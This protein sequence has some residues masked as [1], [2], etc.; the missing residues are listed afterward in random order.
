MSISVGK[1]IRLLGKNG[2]EEIIEYDLTENEKNDLIES[3][4]AVK[5]T[6]DAMENLS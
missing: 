5:E 6:V 3:A 4:K 1:A 2:I